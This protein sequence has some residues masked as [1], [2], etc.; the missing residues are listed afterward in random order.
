V[1]AEEEDG[2]DEVAATGRAGTRRSASG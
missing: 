2:G 1:G